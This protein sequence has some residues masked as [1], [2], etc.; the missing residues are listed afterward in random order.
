MTISTKDQKVD[1]AKYEKGFDTAFGAPKPIKRGRYIQDFN[2]GKLLTQEE[3]DA[4]YEKA[5]V[6][7]P[8][9]L[10]QIAAFTSPIDGQ[11]ITCRSQLRKH[12]EKHGVTNASDYSAGYIEKKAHQRVD[13][14][15]EF[16]NQTRRS[17][18]G[19][20]IDQHTH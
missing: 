3:Y 10:P 4:K 9:V 16:L 6:N 7:A 2:T 11:E 20:A 8:S 13:A 14:G 17:D 19:S 1:K 5:E 18:I 12:N 15:Q